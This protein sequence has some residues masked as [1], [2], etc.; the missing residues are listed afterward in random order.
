MQSKYYHLAGSNFSFLMLCKTVLLT[1]DGVL[2]AMKYSI[3]E[4]ISLHTLGLQS[5]IYYNWN[6][7]NS[8][9]RAQPFLSFQILP[10][11][12]MTSFLIDPQ[13]W[14]MTVWSCVVSKMGGTLLLLRVKLKV[15]W[16]PG[17]NGWGHSVKCIAHFVC[18]T[19]TE[20]SQFW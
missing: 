5:I 4:V 14:G 9:P 18:I 12:K 3:M 20:N 19:H 2:N 13:A 11:F 15:T 1:N 17:D 16:G 10:L 6:D 8:K 7:N